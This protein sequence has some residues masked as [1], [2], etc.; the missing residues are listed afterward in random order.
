MLS[1]LSWTNQGPFFCK[2]IGEVKKGSDDIF[3]NLRVYI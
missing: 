2:H 1:P 3:A